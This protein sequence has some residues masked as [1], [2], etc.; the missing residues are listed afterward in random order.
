MS[1]ANPYSAPESLGRSRFAKARQSVLAC[2]GVRVVLILVTLVGS[3][4]RGS[5]GMPVMAVSTLLAV[6]ATVVGCVI[7]VNFAAA[8]SRQFAYVLAVLSAIPCIGLVGLW[9]AGSEMS[10]ESAS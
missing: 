10:K 7:I 8:T 3:V 1:D 5:I 4:L 2:L 9:L 6:A